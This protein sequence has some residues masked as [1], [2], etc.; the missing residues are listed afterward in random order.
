MEPQILGGVGRNRG[1]DPVDPVRTETINVARFEA[2]GSF[3]EGRLS[4][5]GVIQTQANAERY[6]GASFVGTIRVCCAADGSWP[7]WGFRRF[8]RSVANASSSPGWCR[9]LAGECLLSRRV[10][11]EVSR[12]TRGWTPRK[13][14]GIDLGRF[15]FWDS[16]GGQRQRGRLTK[17]LPSHPKVAPHARR[18]PANSFKTW[19]REH[20]FSCDA[21]D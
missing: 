17:Q 18:N 7:R 10:P 19:Q 5:G 15:G 3:V 9:A 13:S 21:L 6:E 11:N 1:F 4:G 2:V 8:R 12:R 14:E 20:M 16:G